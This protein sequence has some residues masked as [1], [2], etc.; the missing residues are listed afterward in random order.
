MHSKE[1]TVSSVYCKT[2]WNDTL[3]PLIRNPLFQWIWLAFFGWFS[4]IFA[5]K[6][7]LLPRS[8]VWYCSIPSVSAKTGAGAGVIVDLLKRQR[9]TPN[10]YRIDD[11]ATWKSQV[12]PRCSSIPTVGMVGLT[13]SQCRQYLLLVLSPLYTELL[14]V[15]ELIWIYLNTWK[16]RSFRTTN[17]QWCCAWN[18]IR[19][20]FINEWLLLCIVTG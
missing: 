20:S 13:T 4:C 6:I 15:L 14:E 18:C 2:F 5:R 17:V 10:T 1:Y 16:P 3:R 11:M 19:P 7:L 8:S 9:R 12:S